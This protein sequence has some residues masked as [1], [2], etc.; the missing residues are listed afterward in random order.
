MDAIVRLTASRDDEAVSLAIYNEVWPRAA[1]TMDEVDSY[2]ASSIAYADHLALL[3]GEPVGSGAVAILPSRPDVASASITVLAQHRGH[4]AGTALY[5]EISSWCA[6][7]GIEAIEEPIEEEDAPS[8]EYARRRGFAEIERYGRMVLDLGGV[9][10]PKDPPPAGIEI[11]S[12][13]ARPE[14]AR[15]IYEVAVEAYPDMP[16]NAADEME[17]YEAWLAHDM[18]GSADRPEATFVALAGDE[19]VG[20]AKFFLTAAQPADAYHDTTGVKRA[21]R[22]RGIAGA[23]KRAQIAWAKQ[24]GYRRLVT[25]NEMRNEPIRRLNTRLGYREESGRVMMRGPLFKA[26]T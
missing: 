4:G 5:R 24:Q 9:E 22:G 8:I 20:F 10:P 26:R 16:G 12:W 15:G 11:V 19:V 1:V 23:L 18:Q 6:A 25:G 7:H 14:L 2:K 21:W 3:D 13:A 17:P